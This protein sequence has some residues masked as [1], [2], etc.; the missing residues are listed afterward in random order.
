MQI[1]NKYRFQIIGIILGAI[2]GFLY[3][4][5]VGCLTGNCTIASIWYHMV[6]YGALMGFLV[7]GMV[8]DFAEKGAKKKEGE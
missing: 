7:G 8:E 3:W 6:P 1:V 2:G 5:Y 4:K